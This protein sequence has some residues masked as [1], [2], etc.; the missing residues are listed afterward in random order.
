M[1]N[2]NNTFKITITNKDGSIEDTILTGPITFT[3]TSTSSAENNF[4]F[5]RMREFSQEYDMEK[6]GLAKQ[7]ANIIKNLNREIMD[8]ITVSYLTTLEDYR[9]ILDKNLN[10]VEELSF[11]YSNDIG[12]QV[13]AREYNS[14]VDFVI[15]YSI[16]N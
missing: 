5:L 10:D 7:G 13:F 14:S 1:V 15:K 8:K 9:V 12:D 4:C 3:I 6:V 16:N 2:L 11:E